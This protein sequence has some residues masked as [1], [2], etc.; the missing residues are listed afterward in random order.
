MASPFPATGSRKTGTS[1]GT[2]GT[3]KAR[4]CSSLVPDEA[5][6]GVMGWRCGGVQKKG[7]LRER[8]WQNL[9]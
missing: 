5:L 9:V 4:V 7:P 1:V 2:R 3:A 6:R 8:A